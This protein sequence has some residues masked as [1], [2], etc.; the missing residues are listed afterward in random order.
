MGEANKHE[1]CIRVKFLDTRY[2]TSIKN[3]LNNMRLDRISS[4]RLIRSGVADG[5]E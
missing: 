2:H 3:E 4:I 5:T 1:E